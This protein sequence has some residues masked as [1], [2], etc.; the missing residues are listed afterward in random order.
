MEGINN[1]PVLRRISRIPKRP[2]LY[3]RT[4]DLDIVRDRRQRSFEAGEDPNEA[5]AISPNRY[6]GATLPERIVHRT[7][8]RMMGG[9]HFIFQRSELGGRNFLGGFVID[10]IIPNPE[11]PL[12]L[13]ILGDYWHQAPRRYSDMERA[14][15]LFSLG[16][17]YAEVWEHD[18]L[19][20]DQRL[21]SILADI[22]G[23][24]ISGNYQPAWS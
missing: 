1:I 20:S 24:R 13:E 15:V 7:L 9:E 6:P 3:V 21:E 16:Y 2:R 17:T 18:I 14:Y 11:P 23:N 12:A 8:T 4:Q 5:R 19:H 10:F 22:L